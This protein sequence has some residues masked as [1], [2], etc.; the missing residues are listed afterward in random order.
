MGGLY[1]VLTILLLV[2]VYYCGKMNGIFSTVDNLNV[3]RMNEKRLGFFDDVRAENKKKHLDMARFFE[4]RNYKNI[5]IYGLGKYY[6][7]FVND[8]DTIPFD[9]IY[10]GDKYSD[11]KMS[12]IGKEV[13]SKSELTEKNILKNC[14]VIVVTS[15]ANYTVIKEELLELGARCDIYSYEDLVYNLRREY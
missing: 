5:L 14:D 4:N 2:I 1:I 12:E 3:S 7:D 15:L 13:Y 9:N 8:F 11:E 10:F 6:H